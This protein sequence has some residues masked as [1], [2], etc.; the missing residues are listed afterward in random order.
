MELGDR[1]ARGAGCNQSPG[2][3]YM[4][5][6]KGETNNR[7]VIGPS[8]KISSSVTQVKGVTEA[9][10]GCFKEDVFKKKSV[11]SKVSCY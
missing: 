1:A 6:R 4:S 10:E 3:S 7:D 11:V 9:R 8:L 2:P 5:G